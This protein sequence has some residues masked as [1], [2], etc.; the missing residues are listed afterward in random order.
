MAVLDFQL[1]ELEIKAKENV[2]SNILV[3]NKFNSKLVSNIAL[4]GLTTLKVIKAE[5]V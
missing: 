1:K 5:Y 4:K 3:E 2:I